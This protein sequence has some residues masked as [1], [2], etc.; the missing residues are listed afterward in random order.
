MLKSV[1]VGHFFDAD[2]RNESSSSLFHEDKR[3]KASVASAMVIFGRVITA[4][5]SFSQ[6]DTASG[7]SNFRTL[8]ADMVRR[9]QVLCATRYSSLHFVRLADSGSKVNSDLITSRVLGGREAASESTANLKRM[10][11]SWTF[12]CALSREEAARRHFNAR[13]YFSDGNY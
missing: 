13:R 5:I 6:V 1:A 2:W 9:A 10:V 4:A 8:R 11:C 3:F 12:E 7:E